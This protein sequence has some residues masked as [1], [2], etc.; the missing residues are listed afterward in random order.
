M[1]LLQTKECVVERQKSESL[2]EGAG[3][4]WLKSVDVGNWNAELV[5][6]EKWKGRLVISPSHIHHMLP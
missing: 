6:Q 1:D 4:G 2:V 3:N 5:S